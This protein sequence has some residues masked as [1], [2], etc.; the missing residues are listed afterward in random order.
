MDGRC[1]KQENPIQSSN[2]EMSLRDKEEVGLGWH[3]VK[4]LVEKGK[5]E[6]YVTLHLKN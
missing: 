6:K 5:Q 3:R 4:N 2:P 1:E